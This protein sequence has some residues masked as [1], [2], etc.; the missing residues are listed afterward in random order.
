MDASNRTRLHPASLSHSEGLIC[1]NNI[2]V[3]NAAHGLADVVLQLM[4][5]LSV[6]L[7]LLGG[8]V[9]ACSRCMS[10]CAAM[11]RRSRCFVSQVTVA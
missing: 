10:I 11:V 1:I 8:T 3:L 5:W 7:K 4:A 6:L 9:H 2:L